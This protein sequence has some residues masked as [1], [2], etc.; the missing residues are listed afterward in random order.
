MFIL[1]KDRGLFTFK[2]WNLVLVKTK[3]QDIEEINT[4]VGPFLEKIAGGKRGVPIVG[5]ES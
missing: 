4:E 1:F 3:A 5:T 2:T